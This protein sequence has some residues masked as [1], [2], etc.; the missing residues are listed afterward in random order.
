MSYARYS[1]GLTEL[2]YTKPEGGKIRY[3]APWPLWNHIPFQQ[4]FLN[5]YF[6]EYERAGLPDPKPKNRQHPKWADCLNPQ[7]YSRYKHGGDC[8]DIP[9]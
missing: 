3:D 7:C 4:V 9:F 2:A 8:C 6:R 5:A 1:T